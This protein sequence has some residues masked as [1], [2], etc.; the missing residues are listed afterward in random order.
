M[1]TDTGTIIQRLER[2][3]V[4]RLAEF[5]A[6]NLGGKLT[7]LGKGYIRFFYSTALQL[8]GTFGWISFQ[9]DQPIGFVFGSI[10][11]KELLKHLIKKSPGGWVF[12]SLGSACMHPINFL[13]VALSAL[14]E[15]ALTAASTMPE[16]HYIAVRSD[17]RGRHLGSSL[18]DYFNRDM[19]ARGYKQYELS[20]GQDNQAAIQFYQSQGGQETGVH[21]AAG[22]RMKQF[23][24]N[25]P[26]SKTMNT[27]PS[28]GP[29]S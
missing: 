11:G 22:M 4:A 23:L 19:A 20:V 16:L 10:Y 5:H 15:R 12:F 8:N 27:Q 9:E 26:Q 13:R 6:N 2:T 18:I 3:H 21:L 25:V 17:Q 24:F 29:S 14:R 28:K 1:K 7:W